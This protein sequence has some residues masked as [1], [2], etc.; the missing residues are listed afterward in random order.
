MTRTGQVARPVAE[1]DSETLIEWIQD[2]TREV[3]FLALAIVAVMF[4]LWLYQYLGASKASKAEALLAQA[5]TQISTQ[6]IPE[7][8][9]SLQRL[10][11]SYRGTPAAGQGLL[12]LAQ[13]LYDQGKFQDGVTR[14]EGA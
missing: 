11:D 8:Q 4:G 14:L 6:R 12:R 3:A 1:T 5:E 10:V 7:A 13:V 9:T 2:H